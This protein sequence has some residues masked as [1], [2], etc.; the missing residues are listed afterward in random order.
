[1]S[2]TRRDRS[3]FRAARGNTRQIG[4]VAERVGL[5]LRA[6]RYYEEAGLL[7]PA[8]R[9]PG[10]FRLYDDEAVDRLLVIKK[11]KSLGF[12]LEE[13]RS[14]LSVRDELS[15]STISESRRTE[16]RERLHTWVVLAEEKLATLRQQAGVAEDFVIGL[17]GDADRTV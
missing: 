11:M 4:E 16:L 13:M 2:T 6:V 15:D 8:G 5:S 14:L 9:T 1:M 7:T 10:G 17:H 3:A 12:T